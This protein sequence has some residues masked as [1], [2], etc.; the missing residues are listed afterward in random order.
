MIDTI[1]YVGQV[2]KITQYVS[3]FFLFQRM[4]D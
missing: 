1:E 3:V 2:R 4:V